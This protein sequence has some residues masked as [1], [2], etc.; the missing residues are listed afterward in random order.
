[1]SYDGFYSGLS[2]RATA[3]EALDQT[4]A[5]RDEAV[6]ASLSS[7]AS[8]EAATSASV[9]AA[10]SADSASTSE[11]ITA[12]AADTSTLKASEAAASEANAADSAVAANDSAVAAS[13][14]AA[15][16][17]ISADEAAASAAAAEGSA[18]GVTTLRQ[19]LLSS[20]GSTIVSHTS[21]STGAVTRSLRD[22]LLDVTTGA[23][24]TSPQ[25][26][27]NASLNKIFFVPKGSSIVIDVPAQVPSLRAAW[28]AIDQWSIPLSSTV[29]IKLAQGHYVVN[30]AIVVTHPNAERV[31]TTGPDMS[32]N[33][34]ITGLV[35]TTGSR[36][37]YITTLSVTSVAGLG[38]GD[39]LHVRDMAGNSGPYKIFNGSYQITA[40]GASTISIRVRLWTASFP[41]MVLT[42]GR[43]YKYLAVNQSLNC[44]GLI[45]KSATTTVNNILFAGNMWDY[46]LES[47]IFG[48]EKGTHGVYIGSNTIIDGSGT[49]GGEN[50]YGL[51]GGALS[52]RFIGAVD[53]DQQGFTTAGGA[54]LFGQ[55]LSTSACGR[56]GF[57]VGTSSA[58]EIKF[59]NSS[60][61]YR[62]SLIADYGGTLNTS[63]FE[64]NGSRLSGAFA[65]N[66]GVVTAPNSHF[67]ANTVG[68]DIR[69]G[70]SGLFDAGSARYN[71][72]DGSHFEYGASGSLNSAELSNNGVDGIS[73]YYSSAVRLLGTTLKDNGR[74]NINLLSS[75]VGIS[76]AILSNPGRRNITADGFSSAY[77]GSGFEPI[78][79]PPAS[80]EVLMTDVNKVHSGK[81]AISTLGD[82]QIT[83]DG[84]ARLVV[85]GDGTGHP[86]IDGGPTWGRNLNRFS[87]IYGREYI[88]GTGLVKDFSGTLTPEGNRSA[89]VGSTYRNESGGVGTTLYYKAT[90]TGNTGWVAIA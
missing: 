38:V 66:G 18:E 22:K 8:A 4:L 2:G 17:A 16:A 86:N 24:F 73:A 49:P 88:I 28:E 11:V 65:N 52:G 84:V 23:D 26:A 82:L 83:L 76:G 72:G 71:T 90:G 55:Y 57:Y 13:G 79:N 43:V 40:V 20:T 3:N 15:A 42:G 53:F 34:T 29:T 58:M 64:G 39:W 67:W 37:N 48:T 87:A 35:G 63:Y 32:V 70:S 56:R 47:N 5:A 30:Q 54:G 50:P 81:L 6:A 27:A 19:E 80:Y 62:D 60:T 77:N 41:T 25:L 36:G 7:A 21:T 69:A 85:K 45:I 31:T 59:S 68:M 44:D 74:D 12:A 1:M 78:S 9:S 46:W 14:S 10:A 75:N 33:C 61:Q 89:V 51:S